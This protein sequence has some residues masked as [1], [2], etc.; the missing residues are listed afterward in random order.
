MIDSRE[1]PYAAAIW[2]KFSPSTT[3]WMEIVVGAG[4][5]FGSEVDLLAVEVSASS[6]TGASDGG[7]SS[8]VTRL[9]ANAGFVAAA[10]AVDSR[11]TGDSRFDSSSV[12]TSSPVASP[13]SSDKDIEIM[14]IAMAVAAA[15]RI[16]PRPIKTDRL[17]MNCL[18]S[19]LET[20][21]TVIVYSCCCF[22]EARV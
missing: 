4:S 17:V 5:I 19:Y 2:Y 14:K 12:R 1:T 6:M 20:A 10:G 21:S 8:G 11:G 13:P 16:T 15:A 9:S 7:I 3:W 22:F 18:G